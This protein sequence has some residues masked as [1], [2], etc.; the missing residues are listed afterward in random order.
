MMF[1]LV[2]NQGN[3]RNKKTP[4]TC[5]PRK[6]PQIEDLELVEPVAKGANLTAFDTQ[7]LQVVTS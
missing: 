7:L 5:S 4:T 1:F 2:Q 6:K 3:P